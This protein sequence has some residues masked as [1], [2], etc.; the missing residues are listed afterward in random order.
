[1]TALLAPRAGARALGMG[2]DGTAILMARLFGIRNAALA[3][4]LL[5][6]EMTPVPRAFL[7]VNV[8]IDLVDAS[9]VVAAGRQA[10]IGTTAT[11]IGT[12]LALTG[13]ALGIAGFASQS[14]GRK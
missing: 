3:A 2:A 14:G 13:A 8:F 9:A 4:G 11:T 7:T 12:V 1:M 6:L 10:E 5:R